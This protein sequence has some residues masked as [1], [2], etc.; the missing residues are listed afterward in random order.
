MI[1][2]TI[3]DAPVNQRGRLDGWRDCVVISFLSVAMETGSVN[4]ERCALRPSGTSRQFRARVKQTPAVY[5]H[6][7]A[8]WHSEMAR[9]V[10]PTTG[11]RTPGGRWG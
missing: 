4:P 6:A 3:G 10:R 9:R 8:V 11:S 5:R 7:Q 2:Y 1:R